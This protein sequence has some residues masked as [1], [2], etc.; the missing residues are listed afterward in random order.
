MQIHYPVEALRQVQSADIKMKLLEIQVATF[1]SSSF[2][3]RYEECCEKF[4]PNKY[5]WTSRVSLSISSVF[6]ECR[7]AMSFTS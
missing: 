3:L 1:L 6:T 2:Y 7:I 4:R 5:P